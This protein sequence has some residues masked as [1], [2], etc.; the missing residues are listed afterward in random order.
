MMAIA[1][2]HVEPVDKKW[3]ESVCEEKLKWKRETGMIYVLANI[4][5]QSIA[6]LKHVV[7]KCIHPKFIIFV[8]YIF[9]GYES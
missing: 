6:I 1:Q 2:N 8:I 7:S 5:K 3:S 9:I 4:R